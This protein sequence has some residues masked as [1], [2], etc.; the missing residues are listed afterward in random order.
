ML[1][2]AIPHRLSDAGCLAHARN[3]HIHAE[4]LRD[5]AE[6]PALT[7]GRRTALLRNAEVAE[8]QARQRLRTR[9]AR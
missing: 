5:G 7:T 2:H 3:L 1:I 6:A 8:Q 9:H 4:L